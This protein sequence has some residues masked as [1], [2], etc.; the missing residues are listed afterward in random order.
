M[1]WGLGVSL[2]LPL[3]SAFS[4]LSPLPPVSPFIPYLHLLLVQQY[5]EIPVKWWRKQWPNKRMYNLCA[6]CNNSKWRV[7]SEEGGAVGGGGCL[8]VAALVT[9]AFVSLSVYRSYLCVFLSMY[10]L[11]KS[12]QWT[13]LNPASKAALQQ[14]RQLSTVICF[15]YYYIYSIICTTENPF[16]KGKLQLMF[17]RCSKQLVQFWWPHFLNTYKMLRL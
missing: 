10:L 6:K 14:R 3:S 4:T 1:N 8:E 16:S 15:Y 7:R 9:S 11:A 12:G 17:T 13:T 5:D 2:A